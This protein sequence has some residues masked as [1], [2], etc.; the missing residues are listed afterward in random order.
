MWSLESPLPDTVPLDGHLAWL[1][2][3]VESKADVLA[4]LQAN[5]YEVDCFCFVEVLSGQGGVS[6]SPLVL[7]TL[8]RLSVE[9]DLDIYASGDDE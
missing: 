9:L 4:G 7:S 6:V 2:G 3:Q 1:C 5:G 8:G